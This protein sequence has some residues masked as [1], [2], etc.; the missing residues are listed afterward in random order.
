M[1][2][3]VLVERGGPVITHFL[4]VDDSLIFKEAKKEYGEKLKELLT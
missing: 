1:I 3:G 2:G 4:F